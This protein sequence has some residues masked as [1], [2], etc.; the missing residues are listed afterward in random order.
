MSSHGRTGVSRWVFGSVAEHVARQSHIPVLVLRPHQ[1]P[2]WTEG[3][4]LIESPKAPA[5]T[6][7][8]LPALHVLVPLD[9]SPLSEAVL[10]PAVECAGALVRGVEQAIMAP[11]GSV[12]AVLHLVLVVRPSDS[13]AEN[14]PECL[15]VS[16]AE[17]YLR[18][19]AERTRLAHPG[20][21]VTW[22]VASARDVANYLVTMLE[23]H[24][25]PD[26]ESPT[27]VTTDAV[28]RGDSEQAARPAVPPP[29]YTLLAMAT[30]GRS[31][32]TR[33]V[34]GSI[35]ERVVQKTRLP[36]LLVHPVKSAELAS[37]PAKEAAMTGTG[38]P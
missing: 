4:E 16:G 23:D 11:G 12:A 1:L 18:Q 36:L 26:S 13:L 19:V 2:F 33:W 10:E 27:P 35:T 5:Q 21:S 17:T 9:G 15:L 24:L 20:V 22:E 25:E 31:G 34:W 37:T 14:V 30:H 3:A 28:R 7:S 29:P 6:E 32:I 38:G 8:L